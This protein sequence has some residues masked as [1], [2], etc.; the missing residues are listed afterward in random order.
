VN[1]R[2][3]CA[4]ALLYVSVTT[5]PGLPC[6]NLA[7]PS[8]RKSM[9]DDSSNTNLR[10][11]FD[12]IDEYD[13]ELLEL[14][15]E[16]MNDCKGPRS[17]IK[18]IKDSAREAGINMRAFKENLKNHREERARLKRVAAMEAEDRDEYEV[19]REQLG[20]FGSTPLGEAALAGKRKDQLDSL[21]A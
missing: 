11:Y 9:P 18:E 19:L 7:F 4:E 15:S 5:K 21:C 20:E 13:D 17:S 3:P 2:V 8:L 14:K 16:Y 10:P 12:R 1:R 6:L